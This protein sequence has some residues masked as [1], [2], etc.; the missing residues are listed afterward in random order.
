MHAWVTHQTAPPPPNTPTLF[1]AS[2]KSFS[3]TVL[4]RA[5]IA[6]M[7]ASVATLQ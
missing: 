2:K 5:R 1:T 3:V 6:Y 4:R 7:P